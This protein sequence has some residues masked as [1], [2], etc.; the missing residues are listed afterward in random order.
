MGWQDDPTLAEI[1]DN[2]TVCRVTLFDGRHLAETITSGVAQGR[3][4]LA[5]LLGPGWEVPARNSR[6][7]VISPD[8]WETCNGAAFLLRV[9][10]TPTGFSEDRMQIESQGRPIDMF[11]PEIL[12]GDSGALFA[13]VASL[14][15]NRIANLVTYLNGHIHTGV[16]AGVGSSGPPATPKTSEASVAASKVKIT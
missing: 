11:A 4:V 7:V 6:V 8:G 2:V 9:S 16:T 13:A 10:V 3:R 5:Q 12:L 15:D 14:V 1:L